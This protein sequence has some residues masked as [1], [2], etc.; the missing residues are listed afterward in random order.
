[1]GIREKL[2]LPILLAFIGYAGFLHYYWAPLQIEHAKAIFIEQTNKEFGAMESGL[3]RNLLTRDYSALFA[4]LDTQSKLHRHDWLNLSLFNENNK[5]IYPLYSQ[6]TKDP[7]H[8]FLIPYEYKLKIDNDTLGSLKLHLNWRQEHE[9]TNERI[10]QLEL[11]LLATAFILCLLLLLW[12]QKMI[13]TPIQKLQSV[14]EKMAEGDFSISLT[15]TGNDEISNLTRSF[16]LM[17]REIM[18]YQ[19]KLRTAH[20]ETKNALSIVA[21]KNTEL[22]KEISERKK[23]EEQL[24]NMAMYD[25][26]TN[27]PNRRM[28]LRESRKTIAAAQRNHNNAIF[29]FIDLDGFKQ[30]NDCHG[31]EAGDAVLKEIAQRLHS[32]V[33]EIDIVGRFGGDEFVIVLPGCNIEHEL[34]TICSRIIEETKKPVTTID[35]AI[36]IGTSIGVAEY[37]TDATDSGKL[38]SLADEAMYAAK[39]SGGNQCAYASILSNNIHHSVS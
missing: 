19:Q 28:L 26:L 8:S 25:S 33:R 38:I 32:S 5:K 23:I 12:Q 22:E 14:A 30:I 31:H 2:I 15:V 24:A 34:E 10:L 29:L 21:S 3:I 11:I 37:P 1:M 39:Q 18:R 7:D 17:R 13:R 9:S 16:D 35:T 6:Q 4:T 27:L 36:S 20:E